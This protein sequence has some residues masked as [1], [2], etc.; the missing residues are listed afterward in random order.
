MVITSLGDLV[1]VVKEA[2]KLRRPLGSAF[3][4]L[5]PKE[6]VE[7]DGGVTGEFSLP[8]L[9]IAPRVGAEKGICQQAGNLQLAERDRR[10]H[11]RFQQRDWVLDDLWQSK[12]EP[13]H[14]LQLNHTT[15]NH[16]KS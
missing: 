16:Q 8:F 5:A 3:S 9:R 11:A 7:V 10:A 14:S 6:S 1:K 15:A 2:L 13:R 4:P 12:T